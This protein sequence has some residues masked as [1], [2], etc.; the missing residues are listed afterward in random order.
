M[1]EQTSP[2]PSY[3]GLYEC[4]SSLDWGSE[5]SGI[6]YGHLAVL[7]SYNSYSK[8]AL[9]LLDVKST[10]RPIGGVRCSRSVKSRKVPNSGA[11]IKRDNEANR[12]NCHPRD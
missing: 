9:R 10:A 6:V 7:T 2:A 3:P 4:R 5:Y 1:L 8:I 12:L 11:N